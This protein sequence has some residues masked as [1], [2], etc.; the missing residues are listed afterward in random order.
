MIKKVEN[1]KFLEKESS[2]NISDIKHCTPK[3]MKEKEKTDDSKEEI[4]YCKECKGPV[5]KSFIRQVAIIEDHDVPRK[6]GIL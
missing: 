2:L 5:L 4:F 3:V 6:F 1:E